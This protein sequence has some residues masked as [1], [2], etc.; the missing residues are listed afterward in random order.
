MRLCSLFPSNIPMRFPPFFLTVLAAYL[1]FFVFDIE[2]LSM[3]PT[4]FFWGRKL[5]SFPPLFLSTQ[6]AQK[7]TPPSAVQAIFPS[8]FCGAGCLLFFLPPRYAFPS[9]RDRPDGFERRYFA[10]S[11]FLF[12]PVPAFSDPPFAFR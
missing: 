3:P 7:L 9:Q 6:I 11:P 12:V 4:L 10:L 2:Q 1:H 8:T 5:A